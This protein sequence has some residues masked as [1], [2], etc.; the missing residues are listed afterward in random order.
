MGIGLFYMGLGLLKIVAAKLGYSVYLNAAL[1][2]TEQS[3]GVLHKHSTIQN[4]GR[5]IRQ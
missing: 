5:E 1:V 2:Y 4:L 3:A